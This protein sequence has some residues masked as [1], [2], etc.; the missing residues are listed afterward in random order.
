ME[1]AFAFTIVI[2]FFVVVLN[3]V[4]LYMRLKRDKKRKPT[5]PTMEE[6][7]AALHRHREIQFRIDR[8]QEQLAYRV[9]MRNKMLDLFEE[10][11]RKSAED[12]SKKPGDSD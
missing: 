4:M 9:E 10:V 1:S 6:E 5:S 7:Q 8:E 2:L 11:R 12:E 3:F